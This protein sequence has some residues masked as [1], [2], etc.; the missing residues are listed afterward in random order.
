MVTSPARCEELAAILAGSDAWLVEDAALQF[1]APQEDQRF[2][3]A[4]R[5]ER[6]SAVT[7]TFRMVARSTATPP[8]LIGVR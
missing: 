1:L 8:N 6:V 5:P 3:S 4:V 7:R 2:L